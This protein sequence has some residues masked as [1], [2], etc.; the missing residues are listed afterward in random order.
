MAALLA[1]STLSPAHPARGDAARLSQP[2]PGDARRSLDL[3]ASQET[4]MAKGQKRSNR[5]T[6]KPKQTGPKPTT[7]AGSL[8]GSGPRPSIFA[9]PTGSKG[10][11]R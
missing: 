10:P 4:T 9:A 6:R 2:L 7:A 5:E 1:A 11:G 3:P 8:G